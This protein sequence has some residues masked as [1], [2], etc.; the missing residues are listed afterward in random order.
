MT[1]KGLGAATAM[2]KN[3]ESMPA[4]QEQLGKTYDAMKKT[5]EGFGL[6]TAEAEALTREILHIPPGVDVKSWMSDEAKRMAEQTKGA[7][8]AIDGRTVKTYTEHQEKTIKIIETQIRGDS[9]NGGDPSMT[10]FD[11][12]AF[13]PGRA[14]GGRVPGFAEGGKLP[15]TGP[16]TGMT[17][18][19]LGID[20]VGMPRVR[21]DAG[22]WIINP[23]SSDRYNRELAAINA[24]TFPKMPGYANGGRAG[25]EYSAQHFGYG[26][27]R[28]A[29]SG[30]AGA[31]FGDV[32][33]TEQSD[34]VAT[35]HEFARRT[36]ALAT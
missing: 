16:G 20:S 5:A 23:D 36:Q 34:P 22:E 10:A 9:G 15:T 7:M 24:G 29:G 17:D 14:A 35:F 12:G 30:P 27:Y 31:T 21:V 18:G 28:S 11:P 6:G 25:R 13:A 26:P 33:I 32:I 3:G 2:A 19:F 4:V 1:T 8:D